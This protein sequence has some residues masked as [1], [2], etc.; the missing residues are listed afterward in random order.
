[1]PYINAK[2]LRGAFHAKI[3]RIK[4]ASKAFGGPGPPGPHRS[5]T[6]GDG[7]LI[8]EVTGDEEAID[9]TIVVVTGNEI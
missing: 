4:G 3:R 2:I 5:S 6:T 7:Y 8:P 9:I 1:M